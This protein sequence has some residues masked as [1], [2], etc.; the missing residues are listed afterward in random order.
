MMGSLW[1][2]NGLFRHFERGGGLYDLGAAGAVASSVRRSSGLWRVRVSLDS[3]RHAVH[4]RL[5][6]AFGAANPQQRRAAK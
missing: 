5:R 6:N 3:K 1:A 2:Y 4:N